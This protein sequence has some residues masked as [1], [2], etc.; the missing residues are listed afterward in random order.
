MA[1]IWTVNG[2]KDGEISV[3]GPTSKDMKGKDHLLTICVF[4]K[5]ENK[6]VALVELD[7]DDAVLLMQYILVNT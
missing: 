2:P 4:S 7:K 3:S 5:T 6:R 1:R